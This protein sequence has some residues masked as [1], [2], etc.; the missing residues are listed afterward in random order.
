MLSSEHA[1]YSA[2]RE[3]IDMATR[4]VPPDDPELLADLLKGTAA[5]PQATQPA[6]QAQRTSKRTRAA[7][8]ADVPFHVAAIA[9]W[10]ALWLVG[11]YFTL[12]ALHDWGLPVAVAIDWPWKLS[13][14]AL[15]SWLV[16]VAVSALEM[17][18]DRRRGPALLAF[19]GVSVFDLTTTGLGLFAWADVRFKVAAEL[20]IAGVA[21][22]AFGLTFAPERGL[23]HAVTELWK[24]VR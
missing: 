11:G 24:I 13:G 15:A 14:A 21:L 8:W 20:V 7:T 2:R 23:R 10:L 6:E 9:L 17:G 19:I 12:A 4:L 1:H 3:L 22:V 16:P 5:A 18:F